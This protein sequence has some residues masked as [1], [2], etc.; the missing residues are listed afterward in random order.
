MLTISASFSFA[1]CLVNVASQ[2]IVLQLR[3][4]PVESLDLDTTG[5]LRDVY[6]DDDSPVVF[7]IPE[8]EDE[9][10]SVE[11]SELSNLNFRRRI[12]WEETRTLSSWMDRVPS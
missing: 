1:L 2:R 3:A 4:T 11:L 9:G 5:S 8:F 10:S 6:G 12:D 7:A